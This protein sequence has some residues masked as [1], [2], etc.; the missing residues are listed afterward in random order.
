[1]NLDTEYLDPSKP[2]SFMGLN[3][4]KNELEEKLKFRIKII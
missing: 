3:K 4:F 1:M 2:G